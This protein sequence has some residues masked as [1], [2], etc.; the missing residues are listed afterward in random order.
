MAGRTGHG[1]ARR[2]AAAAVIAAGTVLATPGT[3]LAAS[4][5]L[6][7]KQPLVSDLG[8]GGGPCAAGAERPYVRSVP[9]L[10]ARLYGPGGGQPGE[11]S[12]VRGEFEAWWQGEGGAEERVS[13][14]TGTM[15]DTA[16]FTWQLPDT[17]PDETVVSWRVR[18]VNDDGASA[19]SSEGAGAPCEFVYDRTAPDAPAV[20]SSDYPDDDTWSPGVGVLGVF[21]V[22]AQADDVVA[23]SYSFIGGPSGTVEAGADGF[24][25]IRFLPQ[26]NGV[27]ILS[28]QAQD[29]ARNRGPRTDYTFRIGAGPAPVAQWKLADAAGSRSAAAETGTAARAGAGVTFGAPA[30]SGTPLTS[31][32]SLDGSGH[33]FLTPGAP[34][35]TDTA[36]TFAV[37]GWV[38]PGRVDGTRTALSQDAGTARAFTLGLTQ[39]GSAPVWS[40]SIGGA[41]VTGG[42]PETG[43]W[44]HVLG[45]YDAE[46]GTA[47]LYVN[48]RAVGTESAVT[49]VAGEGA[50]QIGRARGAQGYRDRWQGEIGDVRAYDRIVVAFEVKALATRAAR[51]LGHWALDTAPDGLAPEEGGGAPLKLGPGASLYRLDDPCDPQDPEC[52]QD[53]PLE[54]DG[55][56][57]L[58]LDGVSGHAATDAPVIDTSRSFTVSVRVRLT[59]DEPT[60]PMTAISQGGERGDAFKV[61]YDPE[62]SSWDLVMS[63]ADAP[64]APETVL[65]RFAWP[66]GN[67]GP[68]YRLT[69]VHDASVKQVSFYVDGVK[70]AEGGTADFAAAW[71]STGGLQLGRG[72]TADGWGE[73]LH[74]AVDSVFAYEGVLSEEDI[75]QLP[76][77]PAAGY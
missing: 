42:L 30:P 33:G 75:G 1:R 5:A 31:T 36:K 3:V 28:V 59:D 71:K 63:H 15:A 44:A 21:H 27:Q 68:G 7:P 66:D 29:R 69:V 67:N 50:F 25:E 64:G 51:R 39:A 17:I 48:G 77:L 9:Q 26:N 62:N 52:G 13:T 57:H 72:R 73:Y 56:G 70:Y 54:M 41:R 61:R 18:A 16:P 40:F 2:A 58:R 11:V 22:T 14:T 55:D 6:P 45:Q 32:A 76:W 20:T 38:R 53:Q 8:A 37:G 74:G 23:Y 35:V 47:R 46:T 65:S 34:V 19:W 60:R 43:E 10:T 24:A 49:P 4:G 12:R